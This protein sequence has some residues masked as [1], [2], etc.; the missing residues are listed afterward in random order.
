MRLRFAVNVR[1]LTGQY[2]LAYFSV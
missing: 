1:V 2:W